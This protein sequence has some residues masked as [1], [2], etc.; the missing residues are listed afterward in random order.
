MYSNSTCAC[1]GFFA[2]TVYQYHTIYTVRMHWP[3]RALQSVPS[4]HPLALIEMV[5]LPTFYMGERGRYIGRIASYAVN[6]ISYAVC[7]AYDC[8]RIFY[9]DSQ[10]Y[11]ASRFSIFWFFSSISYVFIPPNVLLYIFQIFFMV[12]NDVLNPIANLNRHFLKVS[13]SVA[14]P[15]PGPEPHNF[16]YWNQEPGQHQNV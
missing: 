12:A 11:L 8:Y 9:V 10:R 15:E 13:T 7:N 16:I 3:K 2:L 1:M 14:V 4:H 5:T 6:C